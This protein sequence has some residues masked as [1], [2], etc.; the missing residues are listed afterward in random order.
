MLDVL[1]R[2]EAKLLELIQDRAGWKGIFVDYEKPFV[3]RLWRQW[4]DYRI[5]LHAFEPCNTDE[6]LFHPH[7]WPQAV[8]VLSGEYEMGIGYAA[9][10]QAPPIA[11]RL[12][13]DASS[14]PFVYEMTDINGWHYVRP[15]TNVLSLMITGK[16]WDRWSPRSETPLR[17]LTEG[18]RNGIFVNFE[19]FYL[20]QM[21]Y[22]DKISQGLVH[23]CGLQG[24]GQIGDFCPACDKENNKKK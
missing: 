15:I 2:V 7:P 14:N 10:S 20:K 23:V 8:K 9:G 6:S 21:S 22:L 3:R 19:G 12:R 18:E 16:P 5:S 1:A 13:I 11:C 24:F 4:Q 17:E